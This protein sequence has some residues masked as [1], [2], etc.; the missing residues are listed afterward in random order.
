MNQLIHQ[1]NPPKEQDDF[2]DFA[3]HMRFLI[4]NRSLI[5]GIALLVTLLGIGYA[6]IAQPIYQANIL[7]QVE[8]N[9]GASPGAGSEAKNIRGDLSGAFDIR[10][11]TASEVEVIR[12]RAVASRAVDNFKL[13]IDVRPQYFPVVGEWLAR[14]SSSLSNPGL[15]GYGGY[16]WGKEQAEVSTFNVP[17]YLE[18]RPFVL[19]ASGD[20]SYRLS[21]GDEEMEIEGRVG[22][23]VKMP[24]RRG[25]IEVR[26]DLLE[27]RQ[28]AQFILLRVPHL[29]TVEK[30]QKALRIA[31]KGK[32]SGIIEVTL[33][34]PQPATTS[35]VLNE[36]GQEY[37]RQNVERKSE[38]AQKSLAFLEDRLPHLKRELE[39]SENEYRNLRNRNATFDLGDEARALLQQSVAVKTRIGEVNQKRAELLTRYE[40]AHPAIEALNQ[41]FQALNRQ[42]AVV[43]A[44]VK[45]LPNLE[46]EEV[47]LSRSVK[48]N[49]ELYTTLLSTAQEL[50][51]ATS[52]EV[53]NARL[54]DPARIPV[55]PIEPNRSMVILLSCMGGLALGVVVALINKRFY[56]RVDGPEEIEQL[57]GLPI[58]ATIP[59]N[60][61]EA[62]LLRQ[63]QS[64]DG[65]LRVLPQLTASVGAI[66]S[67][68]RLRASV[69]TAA[70]ESRNNII[71]ITGP[72]PGVGKS[73][74]SANFTAVLASVGK[75]VLLIDGDLRAGNLH[76]YFGL[77]RENG[78][79][80][81]I[82]GSTSLDAVIHRRV[83]DNG[84]FI[85]TGSLRANP[86]E[87]LAHANFGKLLRTVSAE[88]D[89]VVIDTAPVL[90][91][92]DAIA[93]AS[94]AGTIFNIVR[95]GISTV[96]E[97]EEAV[98]Q[99]NQAG[100]AITGIVFNDLKTRTIRYE[101]YGTRCEK[102]TCADYKS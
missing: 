72:T 37:I 32:Q 89:F 74:V 9:T 18:G 90:A 30:L 91:V 79:S 85:S 47:R 36:I 16:V 5:T 8:D 59:F 86:A 46:Q 67:L 71:M 61:K 80:E 21:Q 42:L 41:Q 95:G 102:F 63:A 35:N 57:L 75:N 97:I 28:G 33:N 23:L 25:D 13:Y 2:I 66:E 22:E 48:V 19:T 62:R 73:F 4:D 92:S 38:K 44:R 39:R 40:N 43:N 69:Q 93:V 1:V 70:P 49:T 15:L 60:Q 81:V 53:G 99:L 12:S 83:V 31:E 27:A 56:G 87:L 94:Y 45:Q 68:R 10:T 55:K 24:T 77:E 76:R 51:L 6:F 78:L 20:D 64:N 65:K 100:R 50:R 11:A 17:A 101:G 3:K 34:G 96:G 7:I 98:K 54:L 88:Y 52:S 58:S 29:Q 14:H 84:D 26:V 82:I